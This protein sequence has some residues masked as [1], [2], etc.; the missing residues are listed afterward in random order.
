M[1]ICNSKFEVLD[2][3]RGIAAIG[4]AVFHFTTNWGGY[5]A[6]D[7]FLVLSGF[8]LSHNYLYNDN[9][10]SPTVFISRRIARLYPLHIFTL[11]TYILVFWFINN[12]FP[13]YADGNIFTFVQH[14]TLT[15]NIGIN[16]KGI[17]YNYP[18][19]SVS[20]EFWVSLVFY[21]FITKSTK[22]ASLFAVSFITFIVIY[23]N[24]GHLDTT[25]KNYFTFINSGLLRG[26][27][28]FFLG[29]LSYRIYLHYRDDLRLK[30]Y[31]NYLEIL[32]ILAIVAII[33]G[34]PGKFSGLDIFAPYIFMFAMPVFAFQ[35]GAISNHL[36]KYK[37]LGEISYSIYLNQITVLMSTK[38]ILSNF[39]I[40]KIYILFIYLIILII[41]SH[42]TY[43][44]IEK[45]L[46][47]KG[48]NLLA[49]ISLSKV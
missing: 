14:L 48:R 31:I 42:F 25:Y 36:K 38:Y 13:R 15:H 45:P 40:S 34:R 21:F 24:T 16:P 39:H 29:I 33:F 1:N 10:I 37:Y 2:S 12:N 32:C 43:R 18:S 26:I 44:Y 28:S 4:I 47:E 3:F 41:Y 7:F 20:V 27:A 11:F 30:K 19:W 5:L 35:L 23:S 46:R 6:V 17:T 8:I 22:S 49:K 9:V